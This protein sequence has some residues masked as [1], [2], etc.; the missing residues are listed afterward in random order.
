MALPLVLEAVPL[1]TFS[2]GCPGGPATATLRD[3]L[4]SSVSTHLA[5]ARLV[6]TPSAWRLL[7]RTPG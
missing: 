6:L 1:P 4:R 2:F 3:G 7:R 5:A